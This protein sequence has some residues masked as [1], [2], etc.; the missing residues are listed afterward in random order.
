MTQNPENS[1]PPN[2][3]QK[4]E[5]EEAIFIRTEFCEAEDPVFSIKRAKLAEYLNEIETTRI[6]V[7]TEKE[8][9]FS[10]LDGEKHVHF[11]TKPPQEF[12]AFSSAE[13]DRR[14]TSPVSTIPHYGF[15]IE[16]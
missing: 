11:N 12:P 7:N 10:F 4:A 9:L 6:A 5:I 15:V 16:N 1:L 2:F 13:Y 14:S 3:P 8:E